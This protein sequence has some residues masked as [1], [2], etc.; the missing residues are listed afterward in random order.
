MEEIRNLSDII[1][2]AKKRPPVPTAVVAPYDTMT[3]TAVKEGT[4]E[5]LI[6]AELFGDSAVIEKAA[7]AI[8]LNLKAVKITEASPIEGAI[9]SIRSGRNRLLMKGSVTT[10]A[11]LKACLDKTHGLN[12]GSCISHAAVCSIPGWERLLIIS[13]GGVNVLPSL[14][15]KAD[16]IRSTAALARA[17]GIS[18]P[19]IAILSSLEEVKPNIPSTIDAALLTQ[20]NRRGQIKD[21]VVDGPLALDNIVSKKAAK[22]KGI[23]SEVA[24]TADVIIVPN[25][26]AG[27]ALAKS[28]TYFSGSVNAAI[29]LGAK[30]PIILPSRAGSAEGKWGSLALGILLSEANEVSK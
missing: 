23:V 30:V 7:A 21:C 28:L 14:E 12:T 19:K 6:L 22:K 13:D 9:E 25:I 11:L 5:G 4:E 17:L 8:G 26:E 24:G 1:A 15:Q 3:L 20:M 16:I 18:L 27:N 29:V 2:Q 10:P